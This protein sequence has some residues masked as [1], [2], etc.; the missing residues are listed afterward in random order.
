M[1][2]PITIVTTL[3]ECEQDHGEWAFYRLYFGYP[4]V[5]RALLGSVD[6]RG[7]PLRYRLL[8]PKDRNA[9]LLG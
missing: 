5:A 2:K 6:A 1:E 3:V 7:W 8:E 9:L 4:E